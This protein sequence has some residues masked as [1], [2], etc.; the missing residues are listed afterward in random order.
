M[1]GLDLLIHQQVRL[2]IM[3]ALTALPE[4]AKME[5][6]AMRDLLGVT[7]GNLGAHLRRLEEAG[8]IEIEKT[9]IARKPHTYIA[10]TKRGRAAFKEH[11]RALRE[12]LGTVGER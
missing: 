1:A 4:D 12:I 2:R 8:Y 7:D 9:F 10:A 11:V 6:V 3:A 5:F